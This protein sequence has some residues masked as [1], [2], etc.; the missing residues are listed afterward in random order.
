MN[1]IVRPDVYERYRRRIGSASMLIIDGK[2]QKEAGCI[3]VIA[4]H[5][6]A[7]DRRGI[8]DGIQARDFR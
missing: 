4:R 5:F 3:D 1:V 8:V 2:L 6:D 7:F